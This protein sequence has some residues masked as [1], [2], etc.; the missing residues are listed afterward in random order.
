MADQRSPLRVP[1]AKTSGILEKRDL[2]IRAGVRLP[3]PIGEVRT[4]NRDR[5]PIAIQ[6]R[7]EEL[8]L[9]AEGPVEPPEAYPVASTRSAIE[10][11]P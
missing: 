8:A 6:C 3:P 9:I 4:D 11:A 10:V 5:V 1:V 2:G 7:E